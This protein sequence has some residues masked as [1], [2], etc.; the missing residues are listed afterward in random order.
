MLFSELLTAVKAVVFPIGEPENLVAIHNSYVVDALNQ[1]Q[2]YVHCFRDNNVS[3][4]AFG[5]TVYNCGL[6][7]TDAPD[8]FIKR[9]YSLSSD[10]CCRV[11]F[12]KSDLAT[13]RFKNQQHEIDFEENKR[14]TQPT[15][16][17]ALSGTDLYPDASAN[18][19]LGRGITGWY[20]IEGCRL[21]VFPH[22]ES[23]EDLV[24][25][26]TGVKDDYAMADTIFD[27]STAVIRAVRLYLQRERA[28]DLEIDDS[29]LQKYSAG[30]SD[31][32]G[33]LIW[34]CRQKMHGFHA[35]RDE[36]MPVITNGCQNPVLDATLGPGQLPGDTVFPD[37]P[38]D[39][40]L[41]PI[42]GL[43]VTPTPAPNPWLY[44]FAVLGGYGP[45]DTNSAA[46]AR[47]INSWNPLFVTTTGGS[48]FAADVTTIASIDSQVGAPYGSYM[49]PYQGALPLPAPARNFFWPV[50]SDIEW[51]SPAA[52]A[53]YLAYFPVPKTNGGYYYDHIEGPVHFFFLDS[54]AA[55]PDGNTA[56]STQ[57]EW[58]RVKLATSPCRYK[59]VVMADLAYS[60]VGFPNPV[61]AW[62]FATWGATVVLNGAGNQAYERLTAGGITYL[63]NGL[64]S[65]P[66]DG[67]VFGTPSPFSQKIYSAQVGAQLVTVNCNSITFD[68][69]SVDGVKQDSYTIN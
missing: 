15:A 63:T 13:L 58:L 4:T 59:V 56:T 62:P 14:P 66:G 30:Y 52:V 5:D 55:T 1:I 34:R 46:V 8:G 27:S 44:R 18:S 11:N 42:T 20:A 19:I 43:P 22:L 60:T 26:W 61:L 2:Q 33:D 10:N 32:L 54:N 36:D 12:I 9:V 37:L 23:T 21:Y 39:V 38:S 67:S 53:A 40:T 45:G 48:Y 17:P 24:V 68:F 35:A 25:E 31:A 41:D 57:A 64:G 29:L 16:K 49:L 50:I 6:T 28:R 65:E 3:V 69:Y 47:L 7:V 51:I